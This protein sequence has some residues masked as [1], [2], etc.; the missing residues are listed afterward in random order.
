[1]WA[2]CK[3]HLPPPLLLNAAIT[4]SYCQQF[5]LSWGNHC[6]FSRQS[7]WWYWISA[8]GTYCLCVTGRSYI[9]T[10]YGPALQVNDERCRASIMVN[11][12]VLISEKIRLENHFSKCH[13]FLTTIQGHAEIGCKA[14]Y[15]IFYR[16]ISCS[17]IWSTLSASR[18]VVKLP[19]PEEGVSPDRWTLLLDELGGSG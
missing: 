6:D 11:Y 14:C 17:S 2:L 7:E 8:P 1:M 9:Y 16:S 12:T 5:A 18:S 13:V 4:S 10:V 3:I 15:H 19:W